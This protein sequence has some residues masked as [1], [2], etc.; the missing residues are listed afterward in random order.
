M[1]QAA[2][3]FPGVAA[4]IAAA[5]PARDPEHSD[6]AQDWKSSAR[7][8]LSTFIGPMDRWL[9]LGLAPKVT[10]IRLRQG[11]LGRKCDPT[12]KARP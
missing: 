10:P 3:P 9:T 5:K 6:L 8:E 11:M 12:R 4:L 2:P 7:R 1:P